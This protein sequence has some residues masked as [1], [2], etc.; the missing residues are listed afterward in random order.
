[1]LFSSQ[2]N[3]MGFDWK[4]PAFQ[5]HVSPADV[6]K[7]LIHFDKLYIKHFCQLNL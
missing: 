5:L 3:C 1:M 4:D 6:D 2:K 7:V